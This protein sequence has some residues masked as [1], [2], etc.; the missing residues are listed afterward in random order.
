MH[1]QNGAQSCSVHQPDVKLHLLLGLQKNMDF[2]VTVNI[3]FSHTY[4]YHPAICCI[5]AIFIVSI[6]QLSMDVTVFT[7]GRKRE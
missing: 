1:R 3:M 2:S 5:S 4:I 6:Y 7:E